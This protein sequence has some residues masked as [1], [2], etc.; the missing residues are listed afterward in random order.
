MEEESCN[1]LCF[2]STQCGPAEMRRTIKMSLYM[3]ELIFEYRRPWT[4]KGGLRYISDLKPLPGESRGNTE[5]LAKADAANPLGL[6]VV[7]SADAASSRANIQF[8]KGRT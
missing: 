5:A 7:T 2:R 1:A 3:C 6:T 8:Y 4:S